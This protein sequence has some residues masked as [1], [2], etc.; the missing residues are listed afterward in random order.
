MSLA[1]FQNGKQDN[2]SPIASSTL[3]STPK[4]HQE[5]PPQ[6]PQPQPPQPKPQQH[7]QP[8]DTAAILD[9]LDKNI[10]TQNYVTLFH[11]LEHNLKV[12]DVRRVFAQ[13]REPNMCPDVFFPEYG[14]TV[15]EFSVGYVINM[16]KRYQRGG[17]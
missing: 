5:Q 6:P 15:S 17:K 8:I 1:Y 7:K 4:S 3:Q 16:R 10:N 12:K 9:D 13:L 14:I 11:H 2:Q